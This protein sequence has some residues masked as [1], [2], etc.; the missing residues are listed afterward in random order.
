MSVALGR[1]GLWTSTLD[2]LPLPR[3]LDALRELEADGWPSLWYGEAYGRESLTAA[4]MYLGAT[5]RMVIGTGIASIFGRDALA[6][7]G[8]ARTL[9]VAHPD[10]FVL[11]LGISHAPLVERLRGHTYDKPVATMRD[12]LTALRGVPDGT[13]D[14]SPLPPV[15]V[16]ALGP[17]MQDA[18]RELSDGVH[19]YLVTP[20]HTATTRERIGADKMLVVEQGVVLGGDRATYLERAHAHLEIY[21]GLPNYR[22]SWLRQGFA[23]DDLVRGGSER[24]AEGMVAHGDEAA[25]LARAQEH[26]DAGADSVCLQVLSADPDVSLRA[27]WHRLAQSLPS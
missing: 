22:N 12:Y 15:V 26:L 18:A 2:A 1:I 21:T 17:A 6:A 27:D 4:A 5:E 16:A 7:A 9:Q 10:R 14:Q 19:P 8:A 24:L 23:E 3:A 13:A 11:G 25:L 20:E